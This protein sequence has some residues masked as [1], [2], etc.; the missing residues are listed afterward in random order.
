MNGRSIFHE[1]IGF[2]QQVITR[3]GTQHELQS[4]CLSEKGRYVTLLG[5]IKE[6]ATNLRRVHDAIKEEWDEVTC[7][8]RLACVLS[9]DLK[10]LLAMNGHAG[11]SAT[12]CCPQCVRCRTDLGQ[13]SW[14]QTEKANLLQTKP[15]AC[16]LRA[17][18]EDP[19]CTHDVANGKCFCMNKQAEY[20][21]DRIEELYPDDVADGWTT[22]CQDAPFHAKVVEISREKCY[23]IVAH[24][25]FSNIRLSRRVPGIWHCLHNS[26]HALWLLIKDAASAYDVIAALQHAITELGLIQIRVTTTKKVK[27]KNI[28]SIMTDEAEDMRAKIEQEEAKHDCA[29]RLG[30]NGKELQLVI[31]SFSKLASA[32][33]CHAK[34]EH[35]LRFSRWVDAMSNAISSFNAG[36]AIALAD[37]WSTNRAHEM[38]QHFR[39]FVDHVVDGIGPGCGLSYLSREYT[40]ILP[41]HW[42]AEPDHLEAHA[43]AMYDALGV[44]PGSGTD[45]TTEM[46]MYSHDNSKP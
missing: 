14:V 12:H 3:K 39:T 38:G 31:G 5:R 23:N 37:M 8:D 16:E 27:G 36:A 46:V 29:K 43:S 33:A 4:L 45:A 35:K 2:P 24:P 40:S 32:M 18:P 15:N 26:R 10:Y 21:Q 41:I 44:A 17:F 13:R 30:M 19:T 6:N 9:G 34:P 1:E 25:I 20:L 42:L 11:A 7:D 28:E 22:T